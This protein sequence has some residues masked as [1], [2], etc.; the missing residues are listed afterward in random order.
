MI[1][2]GQ[3][4]TD[5]EIVEL[6]S[7]FK[8]GF[9]EGKLSKPQIMEVVRKVFPRCDA[10]I[11]LRNI[12][13]ALDADN[14]GKIS[15][16]DLMLTFTMAMTGTSEIGGECVGQTLDITLLQLTRSYTGASNFM[17]WTTMARLT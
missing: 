5:K 15:P 10:D 9:P 16:R 4:L 11:V 12:F 8:V 1:L 13:R 17:T 14:S 6:W 7:T 2:Q 3:T